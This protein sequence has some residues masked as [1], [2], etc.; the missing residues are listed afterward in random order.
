MFLLGLHSALLT[1]SASCLSLPCHL[2]K[3]LPIWSPLLRNGQQFT[4]LERLGSRVLVWSQLSS[5]AAALPVSCT[6]TPALRTGAPSPSVTPCHRQA[7]VHTTSSP[8][9]PIF[10]PLAPMSLVPDT[11]WIPKE[12]GML[13]R[14]APHCAWGVHGA[15]TCI[16]DL[17][18]PAAL[19]GERPM[20]L[21]PCWGAVCP[22]PGTSAPHITH[23]HTLYTVSVPPWILVNSIP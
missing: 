11:P 15:D 1:G 16:P 23:L 8:S 4:I 5:S 7:F 18:T 22:L 13:W 2:S 9:L 14:Q 21:E 6:S 17:P 20:G 19:L 10:Q 3:M 12:D